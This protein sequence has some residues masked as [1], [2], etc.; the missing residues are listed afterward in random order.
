[1]QIVPSFLEDRISQIPA[2]QVLQHLGYEY[3][4]PE[5][6]FRLRGGKQSNVILDEVL[7]GQLR[8]INVIRFKG[9]EYPFSNVNISNAIRALKE[10]PYDGLVRTNEKIYDLLCLGKSFEETIGGDA[11]SFTL[12]YI[13]WDHIENNAF[14][15]TAEFPVE[16]AGSTETRRPDI[17][18]FVNGI[19]LV[20][21]ECKPPTLPDHKDPVDVAVSQHIRNQRDDEIC[22]LFLYSQ[23]LLAICPNATKYGTTATPAKFWSI[24]KER[25]NIEQ[26][27]G[28]VVNRPLSAEQRDRLFG[29]V[30][31]Q[32]REYFEQMAAQGD[33]Q[34]TAQDRALYSLCRPERLMELA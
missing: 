14:H 1:M 5:E 7:E 12:K 29:G 10:F 32:C 33:R 22:G 23:M 11:K 20:V 18:L 6:A 31:A 30:F 3:I 34:V 9:K 2:L 28:Q 26:E 4:P 19:P 25:A 21:I 13:D 8:T 17:V 24:W 27:V 16:R 15:V